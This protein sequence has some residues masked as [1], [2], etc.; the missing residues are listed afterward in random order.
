M[1]RSVSALLSVFVLGLVPGAASAQTLAHR[2]IEVVPDVYAA[3]G[4]GTIQTQDTAAVIVNEHDVLLVDTNITPEATRRLVA[5]IRTLTDNPV[6][7]VVNTHWHYDHTD[8]NQIFGPDVQIIGHE[9]AREAIRSGALQSLL[10]ITLQGVPATID[11]LR[12]RV[13]AEEDP[14]LRVSL[15]QQLAVRQAFGKQLK[16]T[17]PTPPNVTLTDRLTIHSDGREIQVIHPGI[18]HTDGDV[19]VYLPAERV[20]IT[21]DYWEGDRTGALRFG[22]HDDWAD[23]LEQLKAMDF[24]HVIPGHGEPFDGKETIAYFQAFLRDLWQ[25]TK[26]L[27]EQQVPVAVTAERVDLTTHAAHYANIRGPGFDVRTIARI[28]QVLDERMQDATGGA[29][30][31]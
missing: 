3:V 26:A 4:N 22:F 21:G 6:R 2:F 13:A 30:A 9:K 28:Y 12:A 8:G 15:E 7:Y 11:T 14:A 29:E 5:D 10:D 27:Y 24:E 19:L 16:E 23:N 20:L 31:R 18:G 1:T 17:V 25:Q